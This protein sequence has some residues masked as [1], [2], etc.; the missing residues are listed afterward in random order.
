MCLH[1]ILIKNINYGN[2][3]KLASFKDTTSQY[4]PVPCGRCSVCVALKQQYFVQRVQMEALNHDLYFGTLT[5]N[6]LSLSFKDYNGLRFAY[7][8]ISDWQK[9]IKMIR[10]H[11]N[12]PKFR[13]FLVTEYGG[14]RHRPHIHFLISFPKDIH[15]TLADR[16]SFEMRLHSIFLKYWRRNRGSCRFPIWQNLCTYYNNGRTRNFDLHYLDPYSTSEGLDAVAFYV[17]KYC[18]KF[19]TWVDKFKSKLFFSLSEDDYKEACSFF[20]PKRLISKGFGGLHDEDIL[21]HINKGIDLALKDP[22]AMY[23]YF[24]SPVN[25]STFPLSPYYS[26]KLLTFEDMEVFNSRKPV[27]TDYDMMVDTSSDLSVSEILRKE[28]DH[29]KVI[30]FLNSKHTYFDDEATNINSFNPIVD[31]TIN[32]FDFDVFDFSD[33]ASVDF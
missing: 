21:T 12:L 31:E 10:K 28:A 29:Q 8:D 5:Y 7:V 19:D 22:T 30:D 4:I 20:L 1:P 16:K 15:Q 17:S 26:S 33:F 3:S 25:G 24:I 27:L 23:P 9:M 14:R 2:T 32:D 6:D 18:L 13:Y 11:E